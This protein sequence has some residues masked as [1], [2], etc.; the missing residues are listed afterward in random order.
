MMVLEN[1]PTAG[2]RPARI[3]AQPRKRGLRKHRPSTQSCLVE[4]L[5]T[6]SLHLVGP[7]SP[8]AGFTFALAGASVE[9]R[10]PA[11]HSLNFPDEVANAC[12]KSL[13][14]RTL[15]TSRPLPSSQCPD[16]P[17]Q[18]HSYASSEQRQCRRTAGRGHEIHG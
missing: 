11:G 4:L 12:N 3:R 8:N 1:V 9:P 6:W 13:H 14:H 18:Q 2:R 16:L 7:A 5:L 15:F 10:T 17:V